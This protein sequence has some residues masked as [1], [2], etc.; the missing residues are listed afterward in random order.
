[1]LQLP[2]RELLLDSLI[3]TPAAQREGLVDRLLGIPP[4]GDAS[5]PA[6][7]LI[8]YHPAGVGA[9]C[10][11]LWEGALGPQDTFVDLGSGLGRVLALARALTG[12]RAIGIELQARLVEQTPEWEGVE[13]R[14]TDVRMAPLHDGSV[15]FLYA[16]FTGNVLAA[17]LERL[18]D[19]ARRKGITVLALGVSIPPETRA[20]L[21]LQPSECFW[22]ERYD[23]HV[24][25][26]APRAAT[27]NARD[28]R[29]LQLGTD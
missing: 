24:E 28:A 10:R 20:W 19:V 9:V 12:C 29:L 7:E 27:T 16:P 4:W 11:A 23:S 3:T 18:H 5:S 17:V 15:F 21:Q 2:D 8:G 1:M 26:I 14:C 22:L 25:G 6:E 13:V